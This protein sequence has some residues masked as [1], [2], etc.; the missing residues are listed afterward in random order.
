MLTI[1]GPFLFECKCSDDLSRIVV[2]LIFSAMFTHLDSARVQ[3]RIFNH[4][5]P[6]L[7]Y[8]IIMETVNFLKIN[9]EIENQNMRG[10]RKFCQIG[11]KFDVLFCS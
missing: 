1:S 11:Y 5:I 8:C 7:I 2:H 10:S 9:E 4:F 6:K 3:V